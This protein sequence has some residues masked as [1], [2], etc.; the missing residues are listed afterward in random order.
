MTSPENGNGN[1]EI[2]RRREER[3]R[4]R[5]HERA[6]NNGEPPLDA[7]LAAECEYR[8]WTPVATFTVVGHNASDE[9]GTQ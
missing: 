1:R 5:A 8:P 9:Q 4:K 7:W 2:D 6:A 3:I